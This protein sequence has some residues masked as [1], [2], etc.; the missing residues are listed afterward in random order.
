MLRIAAWINELA[1]GDV[2][3]DYTAL[4]LGLLWSTTPEGAHLASGVGEDALDVGGI[5][6]GIGLPPEVREE[7]LGRAASGEPFEVRKDPLSASAREVLR[8]AA[9]VAREVGAPE[10]ESAA[11][12]EGDDLTEVAPLHV[13]AVYFF[14]NPANHDAQLHQTWGFDRTRWQGRFRSLLQD[15]YSREM[16]AW[17][18]VIGGDPADSV[19]GSV[20][21]G[22]PVDAGGRALLATA[23]AVNG[24]RLGSPDLLRAV[25]ARAPTPDGPLAPVETELHEFERALGLPTDHALGP[26]SGLHLLADRSAD[27]TTPWPE[28]TGELWA[29]LSRARALA[30]ET[31]PGGRVG[32]RHLLACFLVEEGSEAHGLIMEEGAGVS[33]ARETLRSAWTA[34]H[35]TDSGGAW[36]RYLIGT[37]PPTVAGYHADTADGGDDHLDVTRY[38]TAFAT[39]MTARDVSPPLSI[40]VFGDWG[41][42]KSFFMRLMRRQTGRLAEMRVTGADGRPLFHRNVV[43]IEFNAW[44]Y[45]DANLWASLVQAILEGLDRAM[46]QR[47]RGLIHEMLDQLELAQEAR[48]DASAAV[49][50]AREALE[51]RKTEKETAARK[52]KTRQD[53]LA[54]TRTAD[55]QRAIRTHAVE[56]LS[57]DRV[58]DFLERYGGLGERE[59]ALLAELKGQTD[60]NLGDLKDLITDGQN[61]AGRGRSTLDWLVRAPV[62]P[63][64][65][66]LAV[67]VVVG[68][69]L[70]VWALEALLASQAPAITAAIVEVG[71]A[72]GVV[73]AWAKGQLGRIGTGLD[74]F[75]RIRTRVEQEEAEVRAAHEQ[76]VAEAEARVAEARREL[77]VK[78]QRLA[79]AEERLQ[80]A[81]KELR[82]SDSAQRIARLVERRLEGGDYERHLGIVAAIRR[83]FQTISDYMADKSA[84]AALEAAGLAAGSDDAAQGDDPIGIRPVDRIVLY[85][86]DLDRCPTDKVVA[87]LEAIHLLLAFKLFVV[88]VGVDIR[89]AAR[90]LKDKYPRHLRASRLQAGSAGQAALADGATDAATALDY[91]EKIFQ[92]PFWIPPMDPWASRNMINAL[93]PTPPDGDGDGDGKNGTGADEGGADGNALAPGG[94]R[95]GSDGEDGPDAAAGADLAVAGASETSG[96]PASRTADGAEAATDGRSTGDVETPEDAAD[97]LDMTSAERRLMLLIA[98]AVGKSPRRLKRFVNTYRIL[99]ASLDPLARRRFVTGSVEGGTGGEFGAPMTLM[100]VLT[101]APHEAI[102]LIH[103]LHELDDGALVA[104]LRS[105]VEAMPQGPERGYILQALDVYTEWTGQPDPTV[106]PLRRWSDEVARFSFRAGRL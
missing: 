93:V 1:R 22:Y 36:R 62:T 90:S 106:A 75:E 82:E 43:S 44:H 104:D 46:Q 21:D 74:H 96:G 73:V 94:N 58:A 17:S 97:L 14:R 91:L 61:L 11:S 26:P 20:L 56:D 3:V 55:L 7:V 9:I 12:K 85:I 41:S 18:V 86:D 10:S 53:E 83:D 32:A 70:L 76:A 67:F 23:A 65:M 52:A 81:E 80:R 79:A 51:D 95:T 37:S 88:V 69:G 66:L 40:G 25:F 71:A 15:G 4:F 24:P 54:E 63:R 42:G 72:V 33:S 31:T 38:A 98:G 105:R 16:D 92:I 30:D 59:R 2:N 57:L 103:E 99:K 49:A 27:G 102:G 68:G 100:A 34:R 50:A 60:K 87:V 77:E 28:L 84:E 6:K 45:V 89:W 101:A 29:L 48:K 64:Q 47:S 39:I 5:L 78:E 19:P 13:L 8:R 35:I